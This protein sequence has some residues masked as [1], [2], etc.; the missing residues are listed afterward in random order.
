[1]GARFAQRSWPGG[2]VAKVGAPR[3]HKSAGV[4]S[5]KVTGIGEGGGGGGLLPGELTR[6]VDER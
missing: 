4:G 3:Q 2:L 1:M 6:R 5:Q